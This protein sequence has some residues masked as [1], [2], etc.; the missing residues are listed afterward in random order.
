MPIKF[1]PILG[2]LRYDYWKKSGT[3]ILRNTHVALGNQAV[4][5]GG[6][7][8]NSFLQ[9]TFGA[10]T[11]SSVISQQEI[12]TGTA[13]VW[14]IG[15]M[16]KTV[17]N[18]STDPTLFAG[19]EN[20]T[21]TAAGSTVSPVIGAGL[22][23]NFIHRGTGTIFAAYGE[24]AAVNNKST[25]TINT[26][27][28][29]NATLS[30]DSTGTI[31]NA[32]SFIAK[33]LIN[34][35]GG[36]VSN[37]Y[38]VFIEDQSGAGSVSNYNLYSSGTGSSNMLEGTLKINTQSG[39]LLSS[40]TESWLQTLADENN[41]AAD[42]MYISP[43]TQG[44][45]RLYIGKSGRAIY[46]MNMKYVQHFEEMPFVLSSYGGYD[47]YIIDATR[48]AF[49]M[50]CSTYGYDL[51]LGTPGTGFITGAQNTVAN[52]RRDIRFK[53]WAADSDTMD[54]SAATSN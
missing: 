7:P 44:G 29:V 14:N 17:L 35:A 41:A 49:A 5:N 54:S 46:A 51:L 12:M 8:V 4:V 52:W 37:N 50:V 20:T 24:A 1:D 33:S 25:G 2:Q 23:N 40:T 47:G 16:M 15:L 27:Y 6:G 43:S 38:G 22:F 31:T 53:S 10:G 19:M 45:G 36:T 28:G 3:G 18:T 11:Y 26:V 13:N 48:S 42:A 21:A 32:Y 34:I 39:H 30:N 9:D